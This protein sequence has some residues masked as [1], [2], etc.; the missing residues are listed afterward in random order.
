MDFWKTLLVLLRRWY[1]TVPVLLLSL[2]SAA[3]IFASVPLRYQSHGVVVFTSPVSGPSDSVTM[4][5]GSTNPLLAF[6]STL[7]VAASI[8]TQ[9]L[10]TPAT[11]AEL[12]GSSGD[13]IE[14]ATASSSGPFIDVIVE[15]ADEQRAQALVT[16]VLE[17]VEA[18]LE[19]RQ[20]KLGAPPSSFI[21]VDPVVPP[22]APEPLIGGKMR[23]AGATL[24]LSLA[25]SLASVYMV[26]SILQG[27]RRRVQ[28]PAAKRTP[29][30]PPVFQQR[31]APAQPR[32]SAP[33]TG[34][35]NRSG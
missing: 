27:R 19:T 10:S 24:A 12:L 7:G 9:S 30:A 23:A 35:F 3:A 16:T 25:A 26:E 8:V 33:T 5:R 28:H 31:G 32:S 34:L 17:R 29:V 4:E 22:T 14:F 1:V 15:S 11:L 20:S 18:E 2:G 6:D 13:S 21:V